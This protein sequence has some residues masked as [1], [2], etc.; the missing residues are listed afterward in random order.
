MVDPKRFRLNE[1]ATKGVRN[2]IEGVGDEC[3]EKTAAKSCK[4]PHPPRDPH[5]S[6][7]L[8]SFHHSCSMLLLCSVLTSPGSLGITVVVTECDW[9]AR[10][11]SG[12]RKGNRVT[13]VTSFD[14]IFTFSA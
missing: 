6:V 8:L 14:E 3:E 11:S 5:L 10:C 1:L 2:L 4:E 12:T 13:L 7:T 9:K